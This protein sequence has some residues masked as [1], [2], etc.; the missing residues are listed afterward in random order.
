[1]DKFKQKLYR[2]MYGRY[3]IDKLY[4]FCMI[5]IVVLLAVSVITSVCIPNEIARFWVQAG[6]MAIDV[7][8]VAWS[9]FRFLSKNIAKRRRENEIYLKTVRALA[10]FFTFNTSRKTKSENND[11]A[12]FVFRDCTKC[13]ATL[14]LPRKAGRNSVKCPRCS[15]RFNVVVKKMK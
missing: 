8:V 11:S 4:N 15:H 10:R 1:M 5:F 12:Q 2:F 13:G 6:I 3:G 7:L 9:T 14:R